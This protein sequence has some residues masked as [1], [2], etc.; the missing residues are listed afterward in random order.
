MSSTT[1]N[2]QPNTDTQPTTPTPQRKQQLPPLATGIDFLKK[3]FPRKDPL[4]EGL[5]YRRDLVTLAGRRRHG[6]TALA[7]NL[8]VLL[9][10]PHYEGSFLGYPIPQSRRVLAY[11]LEDDASELQGR[12]RTMLGGRNYEV[13]GL[14][15][16]TKDDF[17][18]RGLSIDVADKL[19]RDHVLVY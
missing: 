12:L 10:D 2:P 13:K 16:R 14:A 19:F 5:L 18:P 9:A 15:L 17:Y 1:P 7:M 6:K 11:L 3:K 4:I 8:A